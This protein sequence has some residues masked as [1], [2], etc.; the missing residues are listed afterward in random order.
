M[1]KRM[2]TLCRL[3]LLDRDWPGGLCLGRNRPAPLYRQ[4][5]RKSDLD[6]SCREVFARGQKKIVVDGPLLEDEAG[7]VRE[8]FW[9]KP[10]FFAFCALF[11]LFCKT[12]AGSSG[13]L[14]WHDDEIAQGGSG[15]CWPE[16][17]RHA[18]CTYELSGTRFQS[19]IRLRADITWRPGRN[20]RRGVPAL[21][22][23]DSLRRHSG[24]RQP[25]DL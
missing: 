4:L 22:D 10:P 2:T 9:T 20:C 19:R 16:C 7:Q 11:G 25:R 14:H 6:L 21:G 13:R 23:V 15:G 8:G 12:A 17:D 24:R 3:D 18:H 5:P 1:G